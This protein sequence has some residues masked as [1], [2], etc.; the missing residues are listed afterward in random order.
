MSGAGISS[1]VAGISASFGILARD[2]AESDKPDASLLALGLDVLDVFAAVAIRTLSPTGG[3][4]SGPNVT[5]LCSYVQSADSSVPPYSCLYTATVAGTYRLDL[6]LVNSA[7]LNVNQR[8]S[9]TV[10]VDPGTATLLGSTITGTGAPGANGTAGVQSQI[11]ITGADNFANRAKYNPFGAQPQY[12]VTLTDYST[13]LVNNLDG[14]F[15]ANFTYTAAGTYLVSV[16]L[17]GQN[18]AGSP[19]QFVVAPNTI[20]AKRCTVLGVNAGALPDGTAGQPLSLSIQ[21]RDAFG[22]AM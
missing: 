14:T 21:A 6:V 2:A 8:V 9:Y 22:N 11:V 16:S 12:A 1:A 7:G 3:S 17:S 15:A 4:V 20:S 13:T 19:F 18:L 10:V 5:A